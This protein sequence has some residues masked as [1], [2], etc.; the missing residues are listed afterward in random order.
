MGAFG[1]LIGTPATTLVSGVLLLS[2][3]CDD[4]VVGQSQPIHL[5]CQRDPPLTYE[6]FGQGI[7]NRHCN[8]C[9]S[10]YARPGQ[11]ADAPLGVDFDTWDDV[12][13]WGERIKVRAIDED[14]MPPA[15]G[16][17]PEERIGLEE[18]LRCEV[19]PAIGQFESA[20]ET[21]VTEEEGE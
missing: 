7:L 18:W 3:S 11:R 17:V 19:L 21:E 16:M 13:F 2:V 8:S 6:N 20:P 10:V 5:N 12:L 4:H 15:G 1:R 9:H 14:T